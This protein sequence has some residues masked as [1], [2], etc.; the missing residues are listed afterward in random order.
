MPRQELSDR[1]WTESLSTS[2]KLEGD[3][4]LDDEH[5][6]LAEVGLFLMRSSV[7]QIG[8]WKYLFAVHDV[9]ATA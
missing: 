4:R 8:Q 7:R 9:D 1:S 6:P 3:I 2:R 5:G